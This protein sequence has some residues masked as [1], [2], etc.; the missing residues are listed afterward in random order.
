MCGALDIKCI[1]LL[2][3]FW[4]A[5]VS[6]P[7]VVRLSRMGEPNKD[8]QGGRAWARKARAAQRVQFLRIESAEG[9]VIRSFFVVLGPGDDREGERVWE[10]KQGSKR[11]GNRS[12]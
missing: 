9:E 5:T 11:E 1:T 2:D 12:G 3:L 4:G 10:P 8:A 7:S 6:S